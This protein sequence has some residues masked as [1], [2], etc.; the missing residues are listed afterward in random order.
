MKGIRIE[1]R[2]RRKRKEA[3]RGRGRRQVGEEE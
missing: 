2:T 3:N 1:K